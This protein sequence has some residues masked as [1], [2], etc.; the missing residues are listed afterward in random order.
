VAP[1][2]ELISLSQQQV[3][4]AAGTGCFRVLAMSHAQTKRKK[5]LRASKL[6]LSRVEQTAEAVSRYRSALA[7]KKE[8][9]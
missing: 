4:E 7:L 6:S 9:D 1:Q 3:Y 5:T 2:D 8:E